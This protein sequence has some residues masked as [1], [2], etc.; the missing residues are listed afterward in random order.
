MKNT[1][2]QLLIILL[3]VG[4]FVTGTSEFVVSGILDIIAGDLH[5]SIPAAGQLITVYSL[6][7]AV[8]AL[9]LV[10]ATSKLNR[11]KVLLSAIFVF[12]LG[13]MLAFF[14]HHFV[15]L[16]LSRVI[17]A[18]S[19]GLYIVVATNYA[20]QIAPPEKREAQWRL[21]LLD[22]LFHSYLVCRLEHFYQVT[23]IGTIFFSS[24]H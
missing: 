22:S 1:S 2:H 13:N 18:M 9:F 11:K 20:A 16:L 19:G 8:G 12:I 21:S 15:L 4:S 6:F 24:L 7:Y 17:M 5:I 3:A 14:S 23:W 10:M